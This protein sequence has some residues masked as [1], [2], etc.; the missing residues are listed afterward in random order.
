MFNNPVAKD[1]CVDINAGYLLKTGPREAKTHL[2]GKQVL[3]VLEPDWVHLLLVTAYWKL[4]M[5][6]RRLPDGRESHEEVNG[7][8]TVVSDPFTALPAL[9]VYVCGHL[10]CCFHQTQCDS[11]PP[12]LTALYG[13]HNV[14][15]L[16][17]YLNPIASCHLF[18]PPVYS[19]FFFFF[20]LL[21][22]P[23]LKF[24]YNS[25]YFTD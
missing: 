3:K 9:Q 5:K 7:M 11:I 12:G 16:R 14:H 8:F 17:R 24:S 10:V 15:C 21:L 25:S 20:F 4:S 19:I 6:Q 1:L 23:H 13:R 2:N 22:W 18:F